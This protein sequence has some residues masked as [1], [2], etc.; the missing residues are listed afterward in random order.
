MP[1]TTAIGYSRVSVATAET[2]SMSLA[3]QET[4]IRRYCA[5]YGLHLANLFTD[6]GVSGSIAIAERP[7]G[8]NLLPE[9]VSLH[10]VVVVAKLDRAFRSVLDFSTTAAYLEK[11][12]AS[13]V[14]INE[15]FDL[16][17]P[18]GRAM[19]QIAVVFAEL[20]RCLIA[21]RVQA[22]VDVR[23]AAGRKIA[24]HAPYGYR[25]ESQAAGGEAAETVQVLRP[26]PDEILVIG[27]I[28]RWR[29]DGVSLGEICHKLD[30]MC[31]PT[32]TGGRWAKTTVHEI[33]EE[34][35]ARLKRCDRTKR[36]EVTP[37]MT[38]DYNDGGH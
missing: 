24:K 3:S 13:L 4:A 25:Y 9:V 19:A 23:R 34:G 11:A 26:C 38:A 22:G 7:A 18:Y 37:E 29:A 5:A 15:G 28:L 21:E 33:C 2:D 20:E 16:R 8:K 14:S 10:A 1:T 32:R 27:K 30:D 35:K 17:T 12:G 31:A 36:N 6:D